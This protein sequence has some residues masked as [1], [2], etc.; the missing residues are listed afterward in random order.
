MSTVSQQEACFYNT[1]QN[2]VYTNFKVPQSVTDKNFKGSVIALFEVDTTGTFKVLYADAPYP[3]LSEETKRVFSLLP[4]IEPSKYD[5]RSSYSKYSI[6]IAIP[7]V[8]PAVFG[9]PVVMD[10]GNKNA[11]IDPKSESKEYE[12]VVYKKFDNPQYKSSLNIPFTHAVYSEFDPSLNQVGTNNHTASK[13]YVYTEVTKYQDLEATYKKNLLNKQSWFGRKLWNEHLIALQGDI[14]W[15][16]MDPI[17]DFRLGKDFSSE[18]VDNT[19][20]NTRGINVQGGLGE[21][22][23]FTTSI[24]ESQGRF[25]DYYNEYAESIRPA[26]GNPAIIPG[27]GIAKDFKTDAYDFP[28]A[29]ANLMFAP[30]KFINLQLGY[31]RNFIGDGYRSLFTG[32]AASPY[33]Y[34]KINTTFWKIK[35]TNTYM[36]LK[37]VR[38]EATDDLDGTYGSK[39]MANHY[40]SW[41]VSKRFNVG[42]FESVVWTDTNGRGFDMSFVNPIIFFRS[43]EFSS[44]SKSG[45]ATL[46]FASKYKWNSRVNL[47]GQF[48]LDEF[49]LDDMKAGNKSWKNKFAYQLGAKYYDAF[50]VKNLMLQSEFNLVRPYTYSH[51]N[52]I[53]NY[54]HNNQSMA[55]PWGANFYELA[56]IGRYYKGRWFAN[57]KFTYGV[58]GFDFEK[59]ADG[60]SV[61]YS[62]YGGDIYRTYEADRYAETG[63]KVGQGNKT[64]LLI[65]DLQAGYVVNPAMNLK[66]FGN[67]IYRNFDPTAEVSSE[68]LVI[69]RRSTTWFSIGLRSDLFNWYYDF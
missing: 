3:E 53:T 41:N 27:I 67:L 55:H 60:V 38:P 48:F 2:F 19:F 20:V 42:L 28:S 56:L 35:Y 36:W 43:V 54:G 34:F 33:P 46:G 69:T 59:P 50:K 1:L 16:T 65:A 7:L 22:L 51:S 40:L 24:F 49:S 47:Y 26:G 44:S 8:K 63:V 18:T 21:Q 62:N 29:D 31:G 45:N 57:T 14:Y 4:K 17:F 66:I 25:A 64:N 10:Q 58:K 30:A 5:G 9:A 15:F 37:D 12:S 39:Y 6:K 68:T 61:P 52:V 23:F 13:P 32:D 11:V